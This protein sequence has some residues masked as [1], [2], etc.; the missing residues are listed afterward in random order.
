MSE[1]IAAAGCAEELA[2]FF[3][4]GLDQD[5]PRTISAVLLDGDLP[6]LAT[7]AIARPERRA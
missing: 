3:A 1:H 5:Q 6:G 2:G 4:A 7:R